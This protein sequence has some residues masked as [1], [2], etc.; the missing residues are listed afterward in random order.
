HFFFLLKTIDSKNETQLDKPS[1]ESE[2]NQLKNPADDNLDLY[3]FECESGDGEELDD[4]DNDDDLDEEIPLPPRIK[5]GNFHT[6]ED[7]VAEHEQR[8]LNKKPNQNEELS[9]QM[10]EICRCLSTFIQE[11]KSF[12]RH[13]EE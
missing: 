5:Q 11:Q 4:D 2:Y 6:P 1:Y 3:R 9:A 10:R 7:I 13:I 8:L 12:N